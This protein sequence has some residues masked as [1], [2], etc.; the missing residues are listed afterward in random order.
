M[1][2][3]TAHLCIHIF[4]NISSDIYL[5][6]LILGLYA[7]V[8][9]YCSPHP[10]QCLT[11]QCKSALTCKSVAVSN[12]L[13]MLCCCFY[14]I[15]WPPLSWISTC[16]VQLTV[17]YLYKWYAYPPNTSS[18]DL[19]DVYEL[20]KILP[21]MPFLCCFCVLTHCTLSLFR[22]RTRSI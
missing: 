6:A 17:L 5:V 2:Y 12:T 16:H 10:N 15:L 21:I 4:T 11:C 7:P 19:L 13:F 3:L 1:K 9:V 20:H 14:F 8:H 18:S 22:L